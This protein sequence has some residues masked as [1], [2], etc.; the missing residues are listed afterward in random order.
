MD[1]NMQLPEVEGGG[2]EPLESPRDLGCE[3]LPGLN[4]VNLAEMPNSVEM[5]PEETASST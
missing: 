2:G 3:S 1:G 5:E 4:G